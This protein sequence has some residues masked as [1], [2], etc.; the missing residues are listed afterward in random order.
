[1]KRIFN[2]GMVVGLTLLITGITGLTILGY[3][4]NIN[5][6]YNKGY[7]KG[8]AEISRQDSVLYKVAYYKGWIDA[9]NVDDTTIVY[10]DSVFT[11]KYFYI[12]IKRY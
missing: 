11:H 6:A 7:K 1:M 8:R 4:E 9:L 10:I 2:W 12:E 3:D 5:N